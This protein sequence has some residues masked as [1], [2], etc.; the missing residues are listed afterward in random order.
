MNFWKYRLPVIVWLAIH[1]TLSSIPGTKLPRTGEYDLTYLA[2]VMVFTLLAF[3]LLRDF[4]RRQNGNPPFR[5]ILLV[6]VLAIAW[7]FSDEYHQ[8]YF[9]PHRGWD[10]LDLVMD[11]IGTCL[12]IASYLLVRGW[13]SKK[14]QSIFA[15]WI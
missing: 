4:N 13:I 2:H 5:R 12:G 10:N 7:G 8:E 1:F 14:Q 6:F 15:K 3:L 11:A 9:V